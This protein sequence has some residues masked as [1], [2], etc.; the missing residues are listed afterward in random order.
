MSHVMNTYA[1]LPVAF[2]R[3]QGAWLTGDDGQE[4][5]D[6][7]AGIAVNAAIVLISAAN[8]RL[9]A[10]LGNIGLYEAAIQEYCKTRLDPFKVPSHVWLLPELPKKDSQKIDKARLREE[11]LACHPALQ[12]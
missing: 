11:F 2:T 1:R 9:A 8:A 6:A 12:P 4:Y 5:L 3:G 7:L 10:A